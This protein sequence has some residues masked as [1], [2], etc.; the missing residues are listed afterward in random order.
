M[1]SIQVQN[2]ILR[3]FN[4]VNGSPQYSKLKNAH[5]KK[6]LNDFEED[7]THRLQ[8]F[9]IKGQ[10]AFQISKK[11]FSHTHTIKQMKCTLL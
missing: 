6:H 9:F 1:E 4:R 5:Q 7:F 2:V 3:Q 11:M 10:G 8:Q